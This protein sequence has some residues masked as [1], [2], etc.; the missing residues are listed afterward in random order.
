MF[1]YLFTSEEVV[2]LTPFTANLAER[3]VG[4]FKA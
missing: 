1:A 3:A 4:T 2:A